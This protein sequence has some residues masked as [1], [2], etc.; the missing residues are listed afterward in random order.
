MERGPIARALTTSARAWAHWADAQAPGR[1]RLRVRS[2]P[3]QPPPRLRL[4]PPPRRASHR[5]CLAERAGAQA[6][7]T[8]SATS[9]EPASASTSTAS[10]PRRASHR[11]CLAERTGA[12]AAAT[13]SAVSAEPASSSTPTAASAA[14]GL[15]SP[16][17]SRT[18]WRP[19]GI[20]FECDLRRA[21]LRLDFDCGLRRARPRFASA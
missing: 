15:A 11:L 2:P 6:A 4:R 21:G 12:Q 3:S 8:S 9:A 1:H 16:L 20:D 19:G 13:S 5:Y 14:P 10:P 7:S 18:R 17:P